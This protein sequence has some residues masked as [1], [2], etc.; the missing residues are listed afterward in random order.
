LHLHPP[1]KLVLPVH[2]AAATVLLPL[3]DGLHGHL[4]AVRERRARHRGRTSAITVC[5]V[6][7][8]VGAVAAAVPRARLALC[9]ALRGGTAKKSLVAAENV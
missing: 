3:G 5:A 4:G 9:L 7:V 2:R 1:R 6:V 8:V